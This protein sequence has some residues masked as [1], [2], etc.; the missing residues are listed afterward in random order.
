MTFMI[1]AMKIECFLPRPIIPA[2]DAA[3]LRVDR[4]QSSISKLPLTDSAL[5]AQPAGL[6]GP[7]CREQS[8]P[9]A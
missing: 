6:K 8:Y 2:L 7:V 3:N 9:T 1:A 4:F 5:V